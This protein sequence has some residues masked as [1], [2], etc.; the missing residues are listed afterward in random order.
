MSIE[1][2]PEKITMQRVLQKSEERGVLRGILRKR[3]SRIGVAAKEGGV[4][5]RCCS[6]G[7][8]EENN[9]KCRVLRHFSIIY[10]HTVFF[11][12]LYKM[13]TVHQLCRVFKI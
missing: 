10:E 11:N 1:R 12:S 3:E 2:R 9:R 5:H 6:K 13:Q 7:A 8:D 4:L